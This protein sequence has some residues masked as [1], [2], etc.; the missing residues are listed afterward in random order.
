MPA[1]RTSDARTLDDAQALAALLARVS[2]G[3]RAA[4]ARLYEDVRSRL[5]GVILRINVNHSQAEEVLQEVF[6]NI[7]RRADSYDQAR[8]Q[9][10][11]WLVSVARY[12]AIDSLRERH[13]ATVSTTTV[14]GEPDWIEA[15]ASNDPGPAE[16]HETGD[17]TVQLTRCMKTL[18][19][20]QRQALA[21]AYYQGYSHAEVATHLAQ[22]L[23]SV[24]SWVRRGLLALQRCMDA[25]R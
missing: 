13:V 8:A 25:L 2:L 11:A 4:F 3:D 21:L 24:K 6:I 16:R 20:E 19:A 12:R 14:E 17:D 9:P 10:M 18:T 15:M 23:G 1:S 5:F 22:P 7:W